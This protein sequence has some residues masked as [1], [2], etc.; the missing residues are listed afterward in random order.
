VSPGYFATV[1]LP[2][3]AGRALDDRD[4]DGT[5]RVVMINKRMADALWPKGS[6]I[7][8][9]MKLGV[10]DSLPWLTVVGI[11]GDVSGGDREGSQPRNYAYVPLTQSPGMD[12]TLSIRA[13]GDP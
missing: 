4:R 11:V 8:R 10:A 2:V 3:V 13:D 6:A 7:G 1:K 5:E 12:V 9:H